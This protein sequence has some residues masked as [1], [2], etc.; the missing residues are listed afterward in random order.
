MTVTSA[1]A[2]AQDLRA[3]EDRY[4]IP[5]YAKWPLTLVRGQGA[6]VWDDKG[7]EYID[8]YGG[9]CV[10]LIGH[11][12]PDW[13]AALAQQAARLGF[14]SNVTYNDVRARYLERLVAFAPQHLTRAF[15]CNSGAE[16]N[17]TAVKLALKATGRS[18]VIAMEGGF[19]G[20]TAGALSL[21]HLGHYRAQ[22]P[23]IVRPTV[24]VPFGNVPALT[25]KLNGDVAAVI[26]E[27]IQSMNGMR[28]AKRE[29]YGE[30]VAAC[31][32]NGTLVIFD[33]I[34]TGMGRLGASF[35]AELFHAP[36][37]IVTTAKGIGNGF[38]M[39]AV[40]ATE[41]VSQTVAQGE[42]GTTFGG[43][44]LACAAGM[45]VLEVLERD[46]LVAHAATMERAA[47]EL[48]IAGPVTG[49]RGHGLLLGL[50]TSVPAKGVSAYLMERKMLVGTSNDPNVL[51]LMPPLV[52]GRGELEA[53]Q[54]ALTQYQP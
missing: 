32:A 35:A 27:P 33:E 3:L 49:V 40:L 21:T 47:R 16:A 5:G 1:P 34:Q 43:G 15:L 31:H 52:I 42:Q 28:T 38:P 20:R 54:S 8:F 12:N 7:A 36:A 51:R 50:E 45:A 25:A 14:Y 10:A 30:L 22:F 46:D 41:A 29:Y 24:A 39:G 23:A 11:S 17:E 53:L 4:A 37:D 26:L 6:R 48:L 18:Q 2:A 9:H 44:P 19:H 13:V